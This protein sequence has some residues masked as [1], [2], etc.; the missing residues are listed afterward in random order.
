MFMT[1]CFLR[2]LM[3]IHTAGSLI[4]AR[5][6]LR[7]G[8]VSGFCVFSSDCVV[9]SSLADY[10]W[11]PSKRWPGFIHTYISLVFPFVC[12][13][14]QGPQKW[15]QKKKKL[16]YVDFNGVNLCKQSDISLLSGPFAPS[17]PSLFAFIICLC[18]D[19]HVRWPSVLLRFCW[20][21]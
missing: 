16:S 21:K 1:L 12:D 13:Q 20:M 8:F 11:L 17:A 15:A 7:F 3:W 10:H 6:Q 14:G 19:L 5:L 4:H 2:R 9:A 18:I